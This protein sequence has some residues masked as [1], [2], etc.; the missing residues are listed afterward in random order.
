MEK[1]K[2]Q[3][4]VYDTKPKIQEVKAQHVLLVKER[5]RLFAISDPY[6]T[7]ESAQEFRFQGYW[8]QVFIGSKGHFK[9]DMGTYKSKNAPDTTNKSSWW[10][11]YEDQ[12]SVLLERAYDDWLTDVSDEWDEDAR[13][14][15]SATHF[16][17]FRPDPMV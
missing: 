6:R 9:K 12:I 11:M 17:D 8:W 10:I 4:K 7:G 13:V 14:R 5:R 15:V 1:Q 2:A 16:V 3:M